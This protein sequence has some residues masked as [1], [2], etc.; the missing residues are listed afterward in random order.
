MGHLG[1]NT[2]LSAHTPRRFH[3][4]CCLYAQ[5]MPTNAL[6]NQRG[7]ALEQLLK[8]LNKEVGRAFAGLHSDV[9]N[10]DVGECRNV[11]RVN[12]HPSA[13]ST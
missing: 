12:S 13:L 4:L 9:L 6:C 7:A 11:L 8:P 10:A 1:H 2:H 3:C 5:V